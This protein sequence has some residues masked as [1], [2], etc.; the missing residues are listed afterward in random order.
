MTKDTPA[1]YQRNGIAFAW[2]DGAGGVRFSIPSFLKALGEDDTPENRESIK[3][4]ME[5]EALREFP[6][7]VVTY[8]AGSG[9]EEGATA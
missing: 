2:A 9:D 5:G 4:W 8:V 7:L 3:G 1:A 6:R